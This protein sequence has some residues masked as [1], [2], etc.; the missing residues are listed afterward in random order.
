MGIK[1]KGLVFIPT[2]LLG[3]YLIF[4]YTG[5]NSS[6]LTTREVYSAEFEN[7]LLVHSKV[8]T[9]S[10]KLYRFSVFMSNLDIIHEVNSQGLDFKLGVNKFADLTQEEFGKMI[11][12]RTTKKQAERVLNVRN[13]ER[14]N[15][16]PINWDWRD[17]GAVS[18]VVNQGSCMGDWAIAAAASVEGARVAQ[19]LVS[20]VDLSSQQL[21]DCT[22]GNS[23]H[24]CNGG[25]VDDAFLYI[26]QNGLTSDLIYPYIGTNQ[27]CNSAAVPQPV[28]KITGF[29]D[30]PSN[31]SPSLLNAISNSPVVSHVEADNYV[32]QFYTTGVIT[33][34]CGN[35]LTH[36]VL[37]VGYSQSASPPYYIVKNSWGQQW[38]ES[39][40][41]RIGIYGGAGVCGIQSL[42]S[43]PTL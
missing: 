15:A 41:V 26:Q 36:T 8:Y 39:G 28:T 37:I 21:L 32:W 6:F 13:E 17:K 9:E 40:Y 3:L 34:Y 29:Y 10:E 5:S 7:F 31:D 18:D 4:S 23:D 22:N 42:S 24:G 14:V 1:A 16:A 2:V 38:G 19:G 30:V 27:T 25:L 35:D 20:L 12:H 43:Y 11:R 33:K